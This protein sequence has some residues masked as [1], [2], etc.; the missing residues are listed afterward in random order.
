MC[1]RDRD[2]FLLINQ[3][4]NWLLYIAA[5][6]VQF[7]P[8]KWEMNKS[9]STEKPEKLSIAKTHR[10]A[11]KLFLTFEEEP[12]LP[13]PANKGKGNLKL[14]RPHFPV[15]KKPKKKP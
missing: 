12:F 11:E 5:D 2:N 3:L 9:S 7:I 13:K 14:K 4:A 8:R 15:V 6:E 10:A 1:I